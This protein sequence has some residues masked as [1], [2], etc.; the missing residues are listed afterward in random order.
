MDLNITITI[1][2]SLTCI[3]SKNT[4]LFN[5]KDTYNCKLHPTNAD[6]VMAKRMTVR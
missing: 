3:F 6:K 2:V 1:A 5:E 4:E